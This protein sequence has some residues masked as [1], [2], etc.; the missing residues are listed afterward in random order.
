MLTSRIIP[1]L[2]VKNGRVVKGVRFSSLADAG[3]P[4]ELARLYEEQG[5]DELVFLDVSATPEGRNTHAETVSRVRKELS[6][7]L[8]TGGG[9]RVTADARRLLEAGADKVSVNTAAVETPEL[10]SEIASRFGSQCTILAL[11]AARR[12]LTPCIS[13]QN[14]GESPWEVVIRSG[15]VRTG[16]D[17]VTWAKKAV[18]LGAGEVLLTSWDRD[19]TRSGYDLELLYAV[20]Q[21]VSV[22]IIASGGADRA[23]H[24]LEALQ[25]GADAVLAA[26]VFH[27]RETSVWEIKSFLSSKGVHVRLC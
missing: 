3:C 26:S 14:P 27:Y 5:A 21:A 13:E 11:D 22:P 1:C 10:L 15:S 9:V 8:T 4:V 18:S 20:S 6:I 16:I 23:E 24:F 25:A 19:G 17:A 7:P 2:D 12:E